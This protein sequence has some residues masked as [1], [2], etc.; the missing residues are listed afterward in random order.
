MRTSHFDSVS[1]EVFNKHLRNATLFIL[2]VFVVLV[3][4]LWF[5]QIVNGTTYRI[6]S[7]NNRIRLQ[8]IPPFRGVILDR[9]GELLVGNRPSYDLYVIMEDVKDL[10]YLLES[11]N[12]LT[13]L[14]PEYAARKLGESSRKFPFRPVCLKRDIS[15]RELAMV[16][17]RIFNLPGVMIK[18]RPQ[19][20][21]V[22][23]NFA[24]HLL[25][26]LGEIDDHQL[27]GG[28][29]PNNKQGDLIGKSGIECK[30]QTRLNGRRGGEQ[31]E[32]DAAGCKI[33]TISRKSPVPGD[34]VCLTI[35]KDLQQLAEKSLKGKKGAIVAMNPDS[36]ELLALASTPSFDPNL[37]IG[38]ISESIWREITSSKDYPLQNRALA[39]QYPPGSVSVSYTHLRAHET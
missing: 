19:R 38:G 20:H 12:Q 24:S 5:L 33:R 1:M 25:G 23:K 28:I 18:V 22:Y 27:K 9:D 39:G 14:D 15:R 32:V 35:D 6:K 10:D 7:E 8:D 31:I 29:Y 34:T 17:T 11:L 21:Y 3:L 37:F 36:G 2:V 26:Y 13:E 4:R 30:W 16:E